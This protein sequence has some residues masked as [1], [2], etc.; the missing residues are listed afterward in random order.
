M[1]EE[2]G[3]PIGRVACGY[4]LCNAHVAVVWP[5]VPAGPAE[6]G[7]G[8]ED[9][10]PVL[11]GVELVGAGL[12]LAGPDEW[13][14]IGRPSPA[15]VLAQ[16]RHRIDFRPGIAPGADGVFALT[17]RAERAWQQAKRFRVPWPRFAL[18]ERRPRIPVGFER[19]P[20]RRV[21]TPGGPFRFRCPVCGRVNAAEVA[22]ACPDDCRLHATDG[23]HF[24][25][26]LFG[27]WWWPTPLPDGDE[28]LLLPWPDDTIDEGL[29]QAVGEGPR[30][31]GP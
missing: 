28:S 3:F 10:G 24:D 1:P 5:A 18:L 22:A 21:V 2:H 7:T 6:I 31:N 25:S 15:A 16:R 29:E 26:M 20:V 8:P 12:R 23:P 27:L 19:R 17:R 9:A 30:P 13:P 4:R 11:A 14:L